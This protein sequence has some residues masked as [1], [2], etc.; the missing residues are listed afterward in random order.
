MYGGGGALLGC[1]LSTYLVRT[2]AVPAWVRWATALAALG[3]VAAIAW[4]PFF[5]VYVWAIVIGIWLVA[6]DHS[7]VAAVVP[8]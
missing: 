5:L 7:R 3:S 1:A 4:F 2:V 6:R 8:A